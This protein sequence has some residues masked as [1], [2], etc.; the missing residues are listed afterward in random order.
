MTLEDLLEELVGEIRD[1]RD[2]I[3]PMIRCIGHNEWRIP[4]RAE[5]DALAQVLDQELPPGDY[6]TVAGLLLSHLGRIPKSGEIIRFDNLKFVVERASDRA[7]EQIRL[8][9]E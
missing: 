2:R 4:A 5:V 7:I 1:E 6:E 3:Q 8:R 9:R